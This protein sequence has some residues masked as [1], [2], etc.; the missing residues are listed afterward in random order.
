[1]RRVTPGVLAGFLIPVFVAFGAASLVTFQAS[2]N[3]TQSRALVE[4]TYDV[5]DT[6][7]AVLSLVQDAETGQR[8]Y[9]I[10]N[11]DAYL[12]PY[13]AAIEAIPKQLQRLKPLVS[14]NPS[15]RD[16]V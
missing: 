5:I 1:M 6:S 2:E 11:D 16:R 3:L 10:T 12:T 15:Q 9:L 7:R 8:G 14:D 13:R 4:R